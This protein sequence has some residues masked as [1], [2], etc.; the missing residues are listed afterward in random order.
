MRVKIMKLTAK[1]LEEINP[2][3]WAEEGKTGLLDIPPIKIEMQ[4][5]TPPVRIKQYPI[6]P[7]GKRGLTPVID[8]LLEEGIL[9]PCMSPHNTPIL[10]LSTCREEGK[11]YWVAKNAATFKQRLTGECPIREWFCMEKVNDVKGVKDLIKEK[12]LNIKKMETDEPL[13][14]GRGLGVPLYDHLEKNRQKRTIINMDSTQTWKGTV[15]TPEEIIKTYGPATWA[16]DGSWGYR[17]PIYMLNRIIRLQAVLEV[18]SNRTALALDHVSHQLAQTRAVV[19]QI[20]LAVDYLLANEG[21]ICG[22]FNSSECCLEIDDR[23]E[24]IRNISKEIRKIAYVGTQEWT[25]LIKIDWWDNFW[26]L[27]GSWW[28]KA[29][30]IAL[31]AIASLL[32][33]PCIL[34]CLIRIV[35]STVQ[36]S[37]QMTESNQ[38]NPR[39]ELDK[40]FGLNDLVLISEA[41]NS[42]LGRDLIIALG[43]KKPPSEGKL[44]IYSLTEE[45]NFEISDTVWYT[46]EAGK[47]NIQ[48]ISVEIQNPEIPIRVKPYPISLEGRKGLKLVVEN[49]VHQGVLESCVSPHNTPILPVKKPDSSYQLVQDLRAV[50]QRTITRFPGVAKPDTS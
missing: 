42:L 34:P 3:V 28:K 35:T 29:A 24:V 9:E 36:A 43:I 23:S 50:N 40:N 21:G 7:E 25:P 18:I 5:E 31:S 4:A 33:I 47:L 26:S 13:K 27:G 49:P 14:S 44:K 17:T 11:Q 6:S 16:Q 15:W 48:P 22:K 10:A 1:D 30:F 2:K 32:L 39:M 8:Q 45:D 37:I 20:K 41:D 12:A 46:G 19:Y 38:G